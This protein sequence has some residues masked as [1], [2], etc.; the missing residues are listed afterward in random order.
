[1]GHRRTELRAQAERLMQERRLDEAIRLFR[2]VVDG[3]PGDLQALLELGLCHL[4][5]RSERAFL[6]VHQR[7]RCLVGRIRVLPERLARLWALYGTLAARAGVSV[8]VMGT[9]STPGY[10]MPAPVYGGRPMPLP[11][12]SAKPTPTPPHK[13]PSPSP[14][15]WARPTSAPKKMLYAAPRYRKPDTSTPTPTPTPPKHKYG[16]PRLNRPDVQ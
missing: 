4:L 15:P 10:A 9:L 6:K 5:N 7:V 8:L 13:K 16:G 2:L 11:S 1:M 14:R 3:H 12:A